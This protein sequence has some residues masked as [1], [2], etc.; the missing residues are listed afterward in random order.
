MSEMP[1]DMKAH[2]AALIDQFRREGGLG[3]QR[4]LLVST[5]GARSGL[6][7]TTPLMYVR[8]DDQLV[9]IASNN[10]SPKA[11]DWFLNLSADPRV[12]VEIG[13]ETYDANAVVPQGNARDELFDRVLE[14]AP[15]FAE[16]EERA[17]RQ[18]PVVVLE[19]S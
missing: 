6:R 1:Q 12:T 2:N 5:T 17:G 18:I 14:Q 9:I 11:P 16:H 13:N 4:M 8:V 15:F 7:R 3:D 10:G 19:R